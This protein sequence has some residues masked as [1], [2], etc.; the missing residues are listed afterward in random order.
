MKLKFYF[1][2]CSLFILANNSLFSQEDKKSGIFPDSI[3]NLVDAFSTEVLYTAYVINPDG[4]NYWEKQDSIN[5]AF[6]KLIYGGKI[7]V[8]EE[9]N[10]W[11]AIKIRINRTLNVSG[12]FIARFAD[13][14]MFVLK[15]DIGKLSEIK[16]PIDQIKKISSKTINNSKTVFE[17]N[18]FLDSL[19]HFEYVN[20]EEYEAQKNNSENLI[21]KNEEIKKEN[22]LLKLK[23]KNGTKEFQDNP[24]FND[25]IQIFSFLGEVSFLNSF[26]ISCMLY[27]SIEYK[28]INKETGEFKAEFNDYPK[29]SPDKKHIIS[30]YSSVYEKMTL[31]TFYSIEKETIVK[32][33]EYEFPNWFSS[34]KHDKIFWSKNNELY[35]PLVSS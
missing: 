32:Q 3:G 22:G 2:F 27:E 7:E 35:L 26:A 31:L 8:I 25:N 34:I 12:S 11:I 9:L 28:F 18:T 14:K 29:I 15:K 10:D 30:L 13:E 17:E 19:F 4:M 6:G 24:S 21:V 5:Q 1:I 33:V 16:V 23:L 20:K